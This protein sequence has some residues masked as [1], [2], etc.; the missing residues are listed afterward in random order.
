MPDPAS[1]DPSHS[2]GVLSFWQRSYSPTEFLCAKT[3]RLPRVV[4][5]RDSITLEQ[6]FAWHAVL[7]SCVLLIF[8]LARRSW[9]AKCPQPVMQTGW[10]FVQESSPRHLASF[11]VPPLGHDAGELI[12]ARW[13][14]KRAPDDGKTR[15]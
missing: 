1:L 2:K 7:R 6:H 11:G 3:N 9:P 12:T 5:H 15:R 8:Q 10:P 13:H 14:Q 4:W